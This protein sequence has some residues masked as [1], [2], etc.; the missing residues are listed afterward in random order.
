MNI[1]PDSDFDWNSLEFNSNNLKSGE[2]SFSVKTDKSVTESGM[3]DVI[4]LTWLTVIMVA[5]TFVL[6]P[7]TP[8]M[9]RD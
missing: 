7:A 9:I 5:L 2:Q 6:S 4:Y 8:H 3:M 1:I